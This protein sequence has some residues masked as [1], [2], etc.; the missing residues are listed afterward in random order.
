MTICRHRLAMGLRI[1]VVILAIA[2]AAILPVAVAHAAGIPVI[3]A[4]N[5]GQAIAQVEVGRNWWTPTGYAA[6]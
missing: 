1:H 5:L 3:D 4:A 6:S 2:I